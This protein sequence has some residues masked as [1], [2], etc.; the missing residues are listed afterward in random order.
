MTQRATLDFL[1]YDWLGCD[2]LC[3]RERFAD[4]SRETFGSVLDMSEKMARDKFAPFNRL[5]DVEEPTFDGE[6]VTLPEPTRE[7]MRAFAEAG[8]LQG[9]QDAGDGGMQLPVAI[10]MAA[11]SF[12]Y[13]ASVSIAAP[14]AATSTH[15]LS[16]S[17][18]RLMA[19]SCE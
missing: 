10:E 17:P 1:L 19:S 3:E 8:L 2:R 13:K 14:R 18:L 6:R 11:L 5:T 7:A 4:H 9:S 16:S 12:F 15:V